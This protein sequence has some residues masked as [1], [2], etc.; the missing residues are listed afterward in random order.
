M[1]NMVFCCKIVMSQFIYTF[2]VKFQYQNCIG[3]KTKWEI[4][5]M[6]AR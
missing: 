5:T 3:C 2:G 6:D 4:P 1:K